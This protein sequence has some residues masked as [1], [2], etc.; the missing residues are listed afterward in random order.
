MDWGRIAIALV[1]GAHGIGHVMGWMP[2]F[3]V[4][5]E[6]VSGRSWVLSDPLGEA[7]TR[8]IATVLWV[9]PTVGFLAM[10]YGWYAG[11]AWWEPVALVAAIVSLVAI[12]LFP[13][14]LPLMSRIGALAVDVVVLAVL[15]RERVPA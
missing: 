14:A 3:G 5:I 7:L 15:I 13:D 9:I 12:A 6:G 4:T 8:I 2:A 11:L 10:A 1:L